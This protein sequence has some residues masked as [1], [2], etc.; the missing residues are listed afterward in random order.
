MK[1]RETEREK[2]AVHIYDGSWDGASKLA[3]F[4]LCLPL[5]L[6]RRE[7]CSGKN[8]NKKKRTRAVAIL[9]RNPEA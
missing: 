5:R 1:E 3:Y 6:C 8:R 7:M 2:N 4:V 9:H